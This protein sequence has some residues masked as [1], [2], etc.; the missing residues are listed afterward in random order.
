MAAVRANR[1][2]R[3]ARRHIGR[4]ELLRDSHTALKVVSPGRRPR[5]KNL[6]VISRDQPEVPEL[7]E[8][9]APADPELGAED[10]GGRAKITLLPQRMPALA[11]A[12]AR[13]ENVARE[14]IEHA[15]RRAGVRFPVGRVGITEEMMTQLMSQGRPPPAGVELPVYDRDP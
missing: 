5:V 6:Q 7:P 14:G 2:R 12:S 15:L 1:S 13:Q 4:P 11:D 3:H 10:N 9:G 8:G